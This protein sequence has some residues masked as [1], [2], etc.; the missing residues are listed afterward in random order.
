M[1]V[2]Y[3]PVMV[4]VLSETVTPLAIAMTR[5]VSFPLMLIV[6][7]LPSIV[8]LLL[9]VSVLASVIVPS[10]L[11]EMVSVPLP[12]IHSPTAEPD[13]VSVLA[14]MIASGRVQKPSS[15]IVL[16]VLL[17]VISDAATALLGNIIEIT[18][19]SIRLNWR[20][21]LRNKFMA[22]FLPEDSWWCSFLDVYITNK[23]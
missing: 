9:I 10:T 1:L 15:A 19:T 16:A 6:C 11:K 23:L 8:I 17:T 7:P 22:G 14:A 13:T 5:T 20:V 2:S 3:P 12:A 4:S 21:F 18:R